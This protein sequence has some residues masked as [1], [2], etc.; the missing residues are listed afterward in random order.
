[1]KS[2]F[3]FFLLIGFCQL[4]GQG[5]LQFNQ[6][7]NL[8]VTCC[9]P[10]SYTVPTGK[11][12][13]IESAVSANQYYPV[14]ITNM[15]GRSLNGHICKDA[16]GSYGVFPIVLPFWVAPNTVIQFNTGSNNGEKGYVSIIE[17]NIIP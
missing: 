4:W 12:W 16:N 13:K 2:I 7:L 6:L 11:V 5:N 1:M 10:T 17:F 15:N 3:T 14:R 9:N 8:E